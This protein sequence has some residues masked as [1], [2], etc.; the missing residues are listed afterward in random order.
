MRLELRDVHAVYGKSHVLHGLT[1]RATPGEVVCLP[2]RNGAGKSATLRS[3][4]GLV[5]ITSGAVLVDG[6]SLRGLPPHTIARLGVGLVP[7]D[8]RIFAA[9]SVGE[10]LA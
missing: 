1:L 2:G 10:N 4:V 5:Q 7:E 3:S 9:L 8:G 6:R